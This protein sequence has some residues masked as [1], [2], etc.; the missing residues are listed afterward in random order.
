MDVKSRIED[1][2]E[3]IERHNYSYYVEAMPSISD[4]EF[5]Q[6]MEELIKLESAY[7]EYAD[8]N[9]PSQRV[10]GT[11]TK[12]FQT[13]QHRS[14][15]LSLSNTYNQDEI[16][17]FI[18]RIQEELEGEEVEYICELKYDGVAI[19]IIYENGFIARAVTRGDGVQG[20]DVTANVK[21]IRSIPM[22]LRGDF[23]S[24]FEIRG[25][26]FMPAESFAKLNEEREMEGLEPFANPRNSAAGSLKMQD[27]TEVAK[28]SLDSYLYFVLADRRFKT[29]YE[30]LEAARSWGFKVPTE[31]SKFV[32]KAHSV[33]EIM[34][35]IHYWD[36]HRG[37][38]PFD[39]DGIVIKVNRYDQQER[40]GFTAKSPK[41]AIAYKFKAAQ[42][43]TTLEQVTYQVG[44]TGAITPVANL[45][46][47]LLAGTT[48]KR[49]SLH[50][51][52]QIEKLDLHEGDTVLVEKGGEI[53][54]K[55]VGVNVDLRKPGAPA[56]I[57]PNNCPECGS[58]LRR[59]EG[60]A[61]HFCPNDTACPPQITGKIEHFIGRKA[62]NIEGLGSETV[63]LLHEK[64]LISN[65][66]DLY[67]LKASDILPLDRFA[68]KSVENMLMGIENSKSIPFE[69]VLFALG[70]RHVGETV[71][72]K[73]AR[74]FGSMEA[75]ISATEEELLNVEEIGTVIAQSLMKWFEHESH[76][77][78]LDRLRAAGLQFEIV[79]AADSS[80]L[81]AGLTFVVS[82]V[83]ET[84]SRDG[85]KEVIEKNGGKVASSVSGK[86]NYVVAGDGMGPSKREKAEKL[87]VRV[88][89][90]VE[91]N[92]MLGK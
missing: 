59:N 63:I 1:L 26:I 66:A 46:P 43:S 50:N 48:V 75:L 45:K 40:M 82:G 36:E 71:A 72:K 39:I 14:P 44:R 62:M 89:S 32:S 77:I 21:T 19:G 84:Y 33:S 56:V 8:V 20:D 6:L 42:V 79:K 35:F 23:P 54:P 76:R 91:F 13:V 53:I 70:I 16:E 5:D 92:Q 74:H 34:D 52:D 49:A 24:D 86:T 58:E 29:H 27:S 11:I 85:I 83:F 2:R 57:F 12:N 51:A 3:T 60:E 47:V 64:G 90:E 25:E 9:S 55:I 30:S 7:P 73:L 15:M 18:R 65:Y 31:K 28:R 38:L 37:G 81:L 10:G 67:D 17:D 68:E 22:K 61:Q 88:I 69:R 87:G 80:D 4:F 78:L 41:W